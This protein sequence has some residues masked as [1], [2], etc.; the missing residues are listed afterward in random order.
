MFVEV[1]VLPV[2]PTVVDPNNIGPYAGA[3]DR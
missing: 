3:A 2:V 1:L